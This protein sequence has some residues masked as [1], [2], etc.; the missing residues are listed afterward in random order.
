MTSKPQ[1]QPPPD[2]HLTLCWE[3][4]P[5]PNAFPNYVLY[6][7]N[8]G[9]GQPWTITIRSG[10]DASGDD[11]LTAIEAGWTRLGEVHPGGALVVEKDDAG[12]LDF[13]TWFKFVAQCGTTRYAGEAA[14]GKGG[15]AG[16]RELDPLLGRVGSVAPITWTPKP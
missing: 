11:A 4:M 12:V 3:P 5:D 8:A 10:M 15:P 1:V 16:A 14:Y 7:V 6:L 2:M 9:T 13:V